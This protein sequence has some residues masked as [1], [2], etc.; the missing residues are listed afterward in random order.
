MATKQLTAQFNVV[1][2]CGWL[3]LFGDEANAS[4]FEAAF[5]NPDLLIVPALTL[6][7]VGKRML[8]ERGEDATLEALSVMQKGRVVQLEPADLF[9]AA[10]TAAKHK[11]SMGDAIIWQT[12]HVHGAKLYTQDAGLRQMPNVAFKA[13]S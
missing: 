11:L 7:E 1:D 9:E 3:A 12:A 8:Q 10:K 5:V 2:S 13:K 6:Y 4:F